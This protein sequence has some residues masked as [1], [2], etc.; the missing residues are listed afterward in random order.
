MATLG[1]EGVVLVLSQWEAPSCRT[2]IVMSILP[3]VIASF[4]SKS[5][6]GFIS[7]AFRYPGDTHA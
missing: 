6:P 2:I 7:D 1:R 4:E 5:S 3:R